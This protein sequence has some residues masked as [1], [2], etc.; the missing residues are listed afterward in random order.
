MKLFVWDYHGILEKGNEAA[1]FYVSNLVL[2]KFGYKERLSQKDAI[3]LYGRKWYEYFEH[4]LPAES[5][6]RHLELQK[7]GFD[8]TASNPEIVASFVKPNPHAKEVLRKIAEKHAQIIIS[9]TDPRSLDIYLKMVDIQKYFPNGASFAAQAHTRDSKRNKISILK[10]YLAGKTFEDIIIIGDSPS[11]MELKEIA[12]GKTYLYCH[13]GM[14]HR[15]CEADQKIHD[16]R[17]LL[18]EI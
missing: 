12:G 17:D 5:H 9:N 16:L 10:D 11:D 1:A 4:V 18:A 8:F 14:K 6:K 15:D 2:E 3:N 7:A 13:P